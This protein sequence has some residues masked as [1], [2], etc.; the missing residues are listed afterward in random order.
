MVDFFSQIHVGGGVSGWLL[1]PESIIHGLINEW[2]GGD[3]IGHVRLVLAECHELSV[4]AQSEVRHLETRSCSVIVELEE[5]G[6]KEGTQR[7][8]GYLVSTNLSVLRMAQLVLTFLLH[9]GIFNH[10]ETHQNAKCVK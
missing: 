3:L 8:M 2:S 1:L 10:V 4:T 6:A 5:G 7:Q 9:F